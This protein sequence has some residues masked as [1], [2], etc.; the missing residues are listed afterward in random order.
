MSYPFKK[1]LCPIQFEDSEQMALT[2]ASQ[3][4]KDMGAT[5]YLLHVVLNMQAV[6]APETAVTA[7]KSAEDD[8]RLKLQ[9]I[10]A[11]KLAGLK[12]EIVTRVAGPGDT[13][14]AVLEVATD[15]DADLIVLK[16]HGRHGLAHFVMGSVAEQ[17]VR[18]AHCSVLTLT[19]TAEERHLGSMRTPLA[20][21]D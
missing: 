19:S 15:L 18:R 3:M 2:L 10:A 16:T 17:V 11:E 21:E 13:S 6:D 9:A 8:A 7:D 14:R 5:V 1:I 4:A 12:F 20:S